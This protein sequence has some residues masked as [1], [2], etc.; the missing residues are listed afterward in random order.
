MH[1][2][3]LTPNTVELMAHLSPYTRGEGVREGLRARRRPPGER[4]STLSACTLDPTP[5]TLRPTPYTLH[6]APYTLQPTP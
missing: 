4:E 5:N 3:P 6:T 1:V 2:R